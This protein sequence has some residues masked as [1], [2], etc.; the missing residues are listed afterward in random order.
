VPLLVESEWTQVTSPVRRSSQ[1]F[2]C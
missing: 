2:T 1:S